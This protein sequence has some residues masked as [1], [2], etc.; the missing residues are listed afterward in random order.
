MVTRSPS[1]EISSTCSSSGIVKLSLY[2]SVLGMSSL[3][4]KPGAIVWSRSG[5]LKIGRAQTLWRGL[6]WVLL[7]ARKRCLLIG[8]SERAT[9]F[10]SLLVAYSGALGS[11]AL[12]SWISVRWELFVT[13]GSIFAG[14]MLVAIGC[15]GRREREPARSIFAFAV[16]FGP[17]FVTL[18]LLG[19]V[20]AAG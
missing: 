2:R 18:A 16:G 20:L 5:H 19:S 11:G 6:P 3:Q 4:V 8:L 7:F 10:L 12:V 17:F 13:A 1:K 14:L 15:A 9:R